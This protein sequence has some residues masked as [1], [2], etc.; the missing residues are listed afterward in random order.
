MIANNKFKIAVIQKLVFIKVLLCV[1]IIIC[2]A[3]QL[4]S[5]CAS[6]S[7]INVNTGQS[8]KTINH[9]NKIYV[10]TV[11]YPI[12]PIITEY[13]RTGVDK[14]V[15]DKAQCIILK[16]DTPGGLTETM[17]D[18]VQ[19]F[20]NAELPVIAYISPSGAHAASA[21]VFIVYSADIAVMASATNIGSAAPVQMD[22]KD[23]GSSM[24]DKVSNDL[25]AFLEAVAK[26]K[27]R[28]YSIVR[29]FIDK[30]VNFDAATA[31]KLNVI[32]LIA[33]DISE[34]LKKINNRSVTKNKIEYKIKTDN[35][36]IIEFNFPNSKKILLAISNPNLLY[37][38]LTLGI[39][40]IIYEL[41][42]P[43][44]GF[45][46]S[47]GA[48]CLVIAFFGF[49]TLP[50]TAA[51]VIL[52]ILG[53]AFI[54][55]ELVLP[56]HGI[57]GG[58]GGI[59]FIIGSIILFDDAFLKISISLIIALALFLFITIIFVIGAIVK[60]RKSQPTIGREAVV[61]K[62]AIAKTP[63]APEGLV[64]YDGELWSAISETGEFIEIESKVNIVKTE[65][66]KLIVK[67]TG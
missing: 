16:I 40:A 10:L 6:L 39:W 30:S 44:F 2:L 31:L 27:N 36:E 22:G 64:F 3:F 15:A 46:G 1:S 5:I 9:P 61:G 42:T 25:I 55:L 59:G 49:Q 41:A 24:K 11:K 20:L 43:G 17:R 33:D 29:D 18:I 7:N 37:I 35:P 67:K 26:E 28:N 38:L 8:E 47:F 60:I 13:L 53:I 65:G 62:S 51:G 45:A 4:P 14:A 58:L 50:V 19:L 48:L 57:V 52:I 66:I 12:T 56:T 23:I 21:G 54:A 34:L 32:D 63:L